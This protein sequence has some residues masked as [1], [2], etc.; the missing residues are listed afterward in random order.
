MRKT[1]EATRRGTRQAKGE[2]Y[3]TRAAILQAA[4]ALFSEVG[5]EATTVRRIAER[6]G[7]TSTTLYFHFPDRLAIFYELCEAALGELVARM[8]EHAAVIAD[9]E[10]RLRA[11]IGDYLAFGLDHPHEYELLFMTKPLPKN[12]CAPAQEGTGPTASAE[13]ERIFLDAVAACC[14]AAPDAPDVD[15]LAHLAWMCG[16][17]L[18]ALSISHPEIEWEARERRIAL[19]TDMIMR[20]LRGL[21]APAA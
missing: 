12:Y 18:V 11:L 6:V 5:F 14:G 3:R 16:H 17:G 19:M 8:R 20:G 15:N 21:T 7:I 9:P 4:R 13:L 2:G 10:A 1:A